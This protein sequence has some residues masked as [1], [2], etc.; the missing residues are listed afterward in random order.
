M[1]TLLVVDDD[2]KVR[3]TLCEFFAK[4]HECHSADRAE[5]ALAFLE[6]ENY[7]VILTDL[8]M[9]GVDGQQLLKR[10]QQTHPHTPVI[11]I[12]GICS[13]EEGQSSVALGAFAYITKPFN[14]EDVEATVNRA[15]ASKGSPIASI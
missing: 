6:F 13:E 8:S 9:P 4:S 2:K 12:S 5:Q 14:L 10:V 7:D 11:I 15:L 1:A 3:D